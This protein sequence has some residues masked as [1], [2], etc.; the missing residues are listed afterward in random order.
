M[1]NHNENEICMSQLSRKTK[2]KE[3]GSFIP[4]RPSFPP[5]GAFSTLK[6]VVPKVFN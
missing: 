6:R 5:I 2:R 3:K 4:D 1:V